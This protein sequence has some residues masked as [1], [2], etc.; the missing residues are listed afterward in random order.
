M[1]VLEVK[2]NKT[3]FKKIA[4]FYLEIWKLPYFKLN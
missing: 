4:K 3:G 1:V 2:A